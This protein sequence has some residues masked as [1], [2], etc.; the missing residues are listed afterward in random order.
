MLFKCCG[1][2]C[3]MLACIGIYFFW[4][5]AF[6]QSQG[7]RYLIWDMERINDVNSSEAKNYE[8]SFIIVVFVS[9][10]SLSL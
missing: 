2:Y 10:P 8:K 6:W 3:A 9:A 7:A 5:L 4:V 1:F